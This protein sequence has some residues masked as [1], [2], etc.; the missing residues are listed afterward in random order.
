MPR[1]FTRQTSGIIPTPAATSRPVVPPLTY[2]WF[3]VLFGFVVFCLLLFCLCFGVGKLFVGFLWCGFW[4]VLKIFFVVGMVLWGL[5]RFLVRECVMADGSVVVAGGGSGESSGVDVLALGRFAAGEFADGGVPE[6]VAVL[7]TKRFGVPVS[8]SD[9]WRA[10]RGFLSSRYSASPLER[11]MLLAEEILGL[12]RDLQEKLG[13]APLVS[14]DGRPG[15][16]VQVAATL[17]Q[18]LVKLGD[19]FERLRVLAREDLDRVDE[20]QA[21]VLVD[22]LRVGLLGT[23]EEVCEAYPDVDEGWLRDVAERNLRRAADEVG[24]VL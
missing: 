8:V 4:G 12:K 10:Y 14:A 5:F 22:L 7:A 15:P 21:R 1:P 24:G 23:V 16:Y 11:Q 9:V 6:D 20:A 19:Q 2:F 18:A 3:L 17:L 13:D